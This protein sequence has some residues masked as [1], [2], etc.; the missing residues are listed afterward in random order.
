MKSKTKN[1]VIGSVLLT[2]AAGSV[3]AFAGQGHGNWGQG[4]MF[5]GNHSGQMQ[6]HMMGYMQGYMQGHMMS[7][8][9]GKNGH[10]QGQMGYMQGKNGHGQGQMGYMQGLN[11]LDNLTDEQKA[12]LGDLRESQQKLMREKRAEM[13]AQRDQ[14]KSK[15]DAILTEE[16]RATLA[17]M[18]F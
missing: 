12:Q 1:I 4:N 10:G 16:Q 2:A 5:D 13:T 9:M 7:N 17:D 15:I 6:G 14:M 8:M 18:G 3:V 11:R